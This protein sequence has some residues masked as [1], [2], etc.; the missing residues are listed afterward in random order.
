MLHNYV[1][2]A[3]LHHVISIL[4]HAPYFAPLHTVYIFSY[5]NVLNIQFWTDVTETLTFTNRFG[6][7][8]LSAGIAKRNTQALRYY[9]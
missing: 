9:R 3:S 2:N 7:L 6:D 8:N 1:S 4:L 5:C